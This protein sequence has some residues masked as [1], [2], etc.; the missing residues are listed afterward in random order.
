MIAVDDMD[1]DELAEREEREDDFDRE[2]DECIGAGCL[3]WDPFHLPSECFTA[4]MAAAAQGSLT[5]VTYR[6]R[7]NADAATHESLSIWVNGALAGRL[8]VRVADELELL[9]VIVNALVDQGAQES[10]P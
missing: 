6:R 9:D 8:T 10:K 2:E 3:H 5:H 7:R 4:E 1:D